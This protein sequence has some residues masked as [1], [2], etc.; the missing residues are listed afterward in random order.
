[1]GT[2]I[3]ISQ[4]HERVMMWEASLGLNPP[5]QEYVPPVGNKRANEVI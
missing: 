4:F 2:G 5:I 3:Q 1:M